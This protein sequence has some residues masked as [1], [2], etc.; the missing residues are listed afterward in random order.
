MWMCYSET[1]WPKAVD[2]RSSIE[3]LKC[4]LSA[5]R[6]D[7]D[8]EAVYG[9]ESFLSVEECKQLERKYDKGYH[10][11]S[12]Y[13][14]NRLNIEEFCNK[15]VEIDLKEF[16]YD[17]KAF[18]PAEV[19]ANFDLNEGSTDSEAEQSYVLFYLHVIYLLFACAYRFDVRI[20]FILL[21]GMIQ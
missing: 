4:K 18:L 2:L 11:C 17:I 1:S 9:M 6:F 8:H 14:R 5:L 10:Y 16:L 19:I 13:L 3:R 7:A 15:L 21:T 12:D 20:M